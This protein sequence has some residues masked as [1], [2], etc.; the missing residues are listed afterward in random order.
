LDRRFLRG[1][2][3][4]ALVA[5]LLFNVSTLSAG[6]ATV[7]GKVMTD[8][9]S[10][11]IP[12]L[13]VVLT[14]R[15]DSRQSEKV[16]TPNAAGAFEFKDVVPGTYLLEAQQNLTPIY[17]KMIN[18]PLTEP[19]SIPLQ[20]VDATSPARQQVASLMASIDIEN[21]GER[22]KAVNTLAFDKN[23][24]TP[25]VVDAALNALGEKSITGL[26]EQGRI[27]C[28]IILSKRSDEKWTADQLS[29]AEAINNYYKD[30][31]LSEDEAFALS[32]FQK[33][34]TRQRS[35]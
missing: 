20:K 11:A 29:R 13:T 7:A 33:G 34:L 5:A 12:G 25:E 2:G 9:T 22:R 16:T 14:P 17:R 3:W 32:E 10:G 27:N 24:P 4:G 18:V 23:V 28:L 6:T 26:S 35:G 1:F 21:Y 8:G 15:K 30:R 19:I 31:K